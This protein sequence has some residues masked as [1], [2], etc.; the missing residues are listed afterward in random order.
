MMRALLARELRLAWRSGAEI[1]NPLWFFLIV[2]TLFPFGVGA[3]PQLL[4]QIAPG[5]V[6]VAAPQLLAQIAPG[7]VWVAALL[8]ALLVMDRL[9][10]DDWQDGSLEQLMLLPTPLVA[11]VLV[12]VVAHWMMSGLPLLIVSPLAALL[13]G[14]SLHDAGVLALTLLLGTPTLSFLGAVGVGLT[15][16]LKR[17]GVL[18]SL[19]VLPLAVPL[20]IFATAACQAAAAGLPVGG[21]LAMLAAFLTASATLCPFA[22]AAAL[23]LT[24]R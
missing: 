14:M 21:Y 24:V 11:V 18:L 22:T 8:A 10:R 12:K 16:G 3:A 6:W 9:F 5:V 7:V 2:I 19:L 20:L 1:L 4:A 13:L 17:G 23:R 15:V